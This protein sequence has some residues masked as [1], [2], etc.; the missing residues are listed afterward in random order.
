MIRLSCNM[1]MLAGL[2][3]SLSGCMVY[4]AASTAVDAG[5]TVVGA[6]AS[7]VSTTADVVTA[8]FGSGDDSEKKS[9]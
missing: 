4:R 5:A 3:L 8:P 7:V 2:A 1:A 9:N 6:G